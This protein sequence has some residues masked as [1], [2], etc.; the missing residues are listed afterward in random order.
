MSNPNTAVTTAQQNKAVE[1]FAPARE[2]FS[3]LVNEE[4]FIK[5]AAFAMQIFQGNDYLNNTSTESKVQ[6]LMNLAD[7]G[8]T[9]NPTMKLAYLI[10]R[11]GKCILEPSYMGLVK[12]LTDTGS[13][14]SIESHPVYEGDECEIDMASDR[15]VLRHTPYMMRGVPMGK[16]VALYSIATLADGAKH[17][18][19]MSYPEIM[20]IKGR[21]ESVKSGRSSP[22]DTDE[23]EMCR[24]TVLKRHTKHLP[25]SARFEALAK[26]IEL[27]NA[28]YTGVSQTAA[29][30]TAAEGV[31]TDLRD[32]FREAFKAYDGADKAE[33]KKEAAAFALS[34]K[35]D[36]EFWRTLIKRMGL[37]PAN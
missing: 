34:G 6:S 19:I 36:P 33:L 7:S 20:A 15:K 1:L 37:T 10:P 5:E 35:V 13:V 12:L 2:H 11:K 26:A 25:K 16:M 9:L 30:M 24:K 4:S 23:V 21:S 3:R 18:E 14:R 28:D 17:F 22:W 27:D 8:L 32:Q 29:P 31:A